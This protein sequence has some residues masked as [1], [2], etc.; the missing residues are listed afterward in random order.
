MCQNV[1][2]EKQLLC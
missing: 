1:F 2:T